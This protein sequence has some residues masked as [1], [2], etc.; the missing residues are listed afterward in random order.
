M[1]KW[2]RDSGTTI[3]NYP[4]PYTR[5][6]DFQLQFILVL[7]ATLP[8]DSMDTTTRQHQLGPTLKLLNTALTLKLCI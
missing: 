4:V 8:S 3:A 2:H 6:C 1:V 7:A 5:F